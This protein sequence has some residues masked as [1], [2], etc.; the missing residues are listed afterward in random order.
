M[1]VLLKIKQPPPGLQTQTNSTRFPILSPNQL[2]AQLL[3]AEPPLV[4]DVREY[5]E[6]AGG[7]L[8]A[9]QVLPLGELEQRAGELP[10]DREIVT[11][12]RTGRR[13]ADAAATL[14][15]MGF[16]NVAELSGGLMAWERAGLADGARREGALGVGTSGAAC[17]GA[18]RPAWAALSLVWP[19]AI[20]LA[21]FVSLG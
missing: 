9:A 16:S 13:S 10:H 11:V 6:F 17:R 15:R 20:V 8:P 19:P 12:C 4:L 1:V 3:T 7:R 5:A 18:A 2:Q 21:W 14:G